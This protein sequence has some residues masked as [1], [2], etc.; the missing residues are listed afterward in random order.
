MILLF[1]M[2]LCILDL[3]RGFI[4]QSYINHNELII[5]KESLYCTS[6]L[7]LRQPYTYSTCQFVS[8]LLDNFLY[9]SLHYLVEFWCINPFFG[10]EHLVLKMYF[11]VVITY[12]L[13]QALIFFAMTCWHHFRRRVLLRAFH[14]YWPGTISVKDLKLVVELPL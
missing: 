9:I 8:C 13:Q 6:I 3:S 10:S 5:I 2:S 7:E 1:M 4:N 14:H 11:T 12:I